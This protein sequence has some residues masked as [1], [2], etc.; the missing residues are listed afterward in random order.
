MAFCPLLTDKF[1]SVSRNPNCTLKLAVMTADF[2]ELL[3]YVSFALLGQHWMPFLWLS[4]MFSGCWWISMVNIIDLLID[5]NPRS[6]TR[7]AAC[8]AMVAFIKNTANAL[9]SSFRFSGSD[10]FYRRNKCA[11]IRRICPVI[12]CHISHKQ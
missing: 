4:V 2:G 8:R 12:Y 6:S 3:I 7:I 11:I 10:A 5:S 1:F 9:G